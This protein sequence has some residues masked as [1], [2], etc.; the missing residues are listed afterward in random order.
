MTA[1]ESSLVW[2]STQ[3]IA[4]HE[5]V[6]VYSVTHRCFLYLTP[7]HKHTLLSHWIHTSPLALHMTARPA[8]SE[9]LGQAIQTRLAWKRTHTNCELFWA[10]PQ[11]S[12]PSEMRGTLQW[13]CST[14]T[15]KSLISWANLGGTQANKLNILMDF[16]VC[17]AFGWGLDIKVGPK[18]QNRG[19]MM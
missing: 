1:L 10:W 16:T 8:V 3:N 13:P 11:L 19:A 17:A 18:F 9:R 2:A 4:I 5:R 14:N 15:A 6:P 12:G 7:F